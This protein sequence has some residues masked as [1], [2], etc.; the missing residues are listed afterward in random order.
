MKQN[1]A[2]HLVDQGF[3]VHILPGTC[4]AEE[5]IACDP[6]GVFL[7]NG[8]GDPEALG[9][10]VEMIQGILGKVPFSESA[11][12]INCCALLAEPKLTS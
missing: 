3:E 6:A 8:P 11:L 7:S 12:G 1:I 9:Y 10:A 4:S 5:V 2:R